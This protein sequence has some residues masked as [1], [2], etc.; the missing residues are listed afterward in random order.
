MI[1]FSGVGTARWVR[2]QPLGAFRRK[3]EWCY[4]DFQGVAS[5][6]ANEDWSC[7]RSFPAAPPLP[8]PFGGK[9]M[10]RGERLVI[11]EISGGPGCSLGPVIMVLAPR[12]IWEKIGR[13]CLRPAATGRCGE[14]TKKQSRCER[15]FFFSFPSRHQAPL[16]ST[17][18]LPAAAL[19]PEVLGLFSDTHRGRRLVCV[20]GG[21]RSAQRRLSV[22]VADGAEFDSSRGRRSLSLVVSARVVCC[23][24]QYE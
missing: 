7:D 9:V 21:L 24:R 4:F 22:L 18:P 12:P 2:T 6:R 23:P 13:Y 17:T 5:A 11:R 20:R 19:R 8:P 10:R 14:M 15:L 16:M 1:F 3:S